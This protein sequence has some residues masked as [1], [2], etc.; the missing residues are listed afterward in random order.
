MRKAGFL[1]AMLIFLL[2][3]SLFAQVGLIKGDQQSGIESRSE[4]CPYSEGKYTFL[5]DSFPEDSKGAIKKY[6]E[7]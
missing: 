7:E 2:G 1:M 5:Y 3:L 4:W 6:F